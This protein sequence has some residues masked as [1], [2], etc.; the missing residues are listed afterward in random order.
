[1]HAKTKKFSKGDLWEVEIL[2]QMGFARIISSSNI[3]YI[4]AKLHISAINSS[5]QF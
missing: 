5:E 3:T 1:M 2:K 4:L